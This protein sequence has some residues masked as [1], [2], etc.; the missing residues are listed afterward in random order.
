MSLIGSVRKYEATPFLPQSLTKMFNCM[1][2]LYSVGMKL[3]TKRHIEANAY[4]HPEPPL[5][6]F[7]GLPLNI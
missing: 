3:A 5:E 7:P 1:I 6:Y 2:K 4:K